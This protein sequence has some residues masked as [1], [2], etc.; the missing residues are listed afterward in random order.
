VGVVCRAK[1]G[2]PV[3]EGDVLAEVHA[4]D[5]ASAAAA[6]AEV[7]AAYELGDEAPKPGSVILETLS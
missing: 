7:D 5:D 3:A 1:R 4:Q 2:D 6:V